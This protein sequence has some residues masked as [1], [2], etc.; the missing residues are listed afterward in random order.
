MQRAANK[1]LFD[2]PNEI[3]EVSRLYGVGSSDRAKPGNQG[4]VKTSQNPAHTN[5]L[6]ETERLRSQ[7]PF[8]KP[9]LP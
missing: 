6:G 9:P 5:K 8:C 1:C 2:N 7:T 4:Y 3:K